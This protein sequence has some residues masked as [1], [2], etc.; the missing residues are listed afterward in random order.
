MHIAAA[1]EIH[2]RL[3]PGLET[4]YKALNQKSKEFEKIIKIGRTHCQVFKKK[5]YLIKLI[6]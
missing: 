3:I 1:L 4:L 5:H 2:N 6:F